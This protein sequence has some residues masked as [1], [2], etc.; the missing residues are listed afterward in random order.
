MADL[1]GGVAAFADQKRAELAAK[2]QRL[3]EE[4]GSLEMSQLTSDYRLHHRSQVFS[5]KAPTESIKHGDPRPSGPG[6]QMSDRPLL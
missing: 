3:A 1:A 5:S 6:E 4:Q 2:M